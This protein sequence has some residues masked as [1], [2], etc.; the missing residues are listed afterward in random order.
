MYK[1]LR[2]FLLA[3]LLPA[4]L[5]SATGI[6]VTRHVCEQC[7][8][9]AF[10]LDGTPSEGC[11]EQQNELIAEPVSCCSLPTEKA[12]ESHSCWSAPAAAT[13]GDSTHG[14][15]EPAGLNHMDNCCQQSSEY[16]LSDHSVSTSQHL[17]IFFKVP[18][19]QKI[20][21]IFSEDGPFSAYRHYNPLWKN[22]GR[23]LLVSIQQ[24][25]LDC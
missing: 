19:S 16:L 7:Q 10:S 24:L 3:L 6:Q 22:T 4:F 18:L 20:P 8:L 14:A 17:L 9:V 21:S 5:A 23:D 15:E 2:I 12:V 1:G 11:C 13:A 25:K